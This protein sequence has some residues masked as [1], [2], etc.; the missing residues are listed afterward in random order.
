MEPM[1]RRTAVRLAG[2]GAG[3]SLAG[4]LG[5]LAPGGASDDGIEY[6]V[7]QAGPDTTR[8]PWDEDEGRVGFVAVFESANEAWWTFDG[9]PDDELAS[10]FDE[11]DFAESIVVS[12]QTVAPNACYGEVEIEDLALGD[13][14]EDPDV[15][16][17]TARAVDVSDEDEACPQVI[18]YLAA[19][20]RVTGD[21][22]PSEAAFTI[23]DG[24]GETS[25]VRSTALPV[26]LD[27]LAG[28]VEPPNEPRTVPSE[29][30]CEDED[31]ERLGS[32]DEDVAWGEVTHDDGDAAFAMRV[33]PLPQFDDDEDDAAEALAFRRGDEV[34]ISLRNVSDR[35]LSTGNEH[36]YNLELLTEAGWT[37]V[38]GRDADRPLPYTDGALSHSPGGGFEWTF[39]LTEEGIVEGHV[40]EDS[41]RVCP[42]LQP[43]R[44]RFRY[45]GV[46]GD[47]SIA[48]AFDLV[49]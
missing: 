42:D 44:Y 5:Q 21:E 14:G 39:T 23:T 13:G 17:G 16:T 49:E 36:K 45:W 48:V 1:K 46:P 26:D 30:T 4:C 37:D 31:F 10:W 47:E 40:H 12:V 7:F 2:A 9:E 20:V 29:L 3:V 15:L 8:P 33:D 43:G 28:Y 11:T 6:E 25:E 32:S 18:T 35:H 38:R 22:L 19:Y 41:L 27:D 34:R 24:W